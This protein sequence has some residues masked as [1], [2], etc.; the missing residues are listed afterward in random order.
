MLAWLWAALSTVVMLCCVFFLWTVDSFQQDWITNFWTSPSLMNLQEMNFCQNFQH[1]TILPATHCSSHL[2]R[3]PAPPQGFVVVLFVLSLFAGNSP[4]ND[5]PVLK[6]WRALPHALSTLG[7][8]N[9]KCRHVL[10]LPAVQTVAQGL[11][12][13]WEIVHR[14]SDFLFE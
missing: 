4:S 10:S 11:L 6:K 1:S 3:L 13:S 5:C 7:G 14:F 12:F 9:R 2:P 8:W